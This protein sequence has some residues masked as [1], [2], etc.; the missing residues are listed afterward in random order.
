MKCLEMLDCF[1]NNV[2]LTERW[3]LWISRKDY[4]QI[5]MPGQ[6]TVRKQQSDESLQ[7]CKRVGKEKNLLQC[8]LD[9]QA[10]LQR[11]LV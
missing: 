3:R 10:V 5:A 9:Q 8:M 11:W 1:H 7:R 2:T 6:E 4:C